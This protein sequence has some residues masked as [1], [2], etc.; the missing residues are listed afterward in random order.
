MA[1]G[2][3]EEEIFPEGEDSDEGGGEGDNGGGGEEDDG[4]DDRDENERG[5]DPFAGH[6]RRGYQISVI[7]YQGSGNGDQRP[8]TRKQEEVARG[9]RKIMQRT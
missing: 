2:F 7:R 4:D 8:A 5:E 9:K 6:G 3:A 1:D